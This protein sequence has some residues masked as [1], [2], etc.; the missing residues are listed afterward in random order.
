[1][2][3]VDLRDSALQL[4]RAAPGLERRPPGRPAAGARGGTRGHPRVSTP[5]AARPCAG[6]AR[7]RSRL[8][9]DGIQLGALVA[10]LL[11]AL[12]LCLSA[13]FFFGGVP[14]GCPGH[15][16]QAVVEVTESAQPPLCP[17]GSS[18]NP[19]QV[20]TPK[21]HRGSANHGLL[22]LREPCPGAAGRG[23]RTRSSSPRGEGRGAAG[24]AWWGRSIPQS[25]PALS[26][27]RGLLCPLF[28]T[29][30]LAEDRNWSQT[31]DG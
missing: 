31:D 18:G 21:R 9:R 8:R 17:E 28:P 13:F 2:R 22:P 6:A 20:K 25:C 4:S 24:P 23:T 15:C 16:S 11:D 14:R 12:L 30:M 3:C 19:L 29:R 5:R 26:C 27:L 1:M 10:V 7:C